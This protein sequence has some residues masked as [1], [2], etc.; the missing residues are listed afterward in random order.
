MRNQPVTYQFW[1]DIGSQGWWS[2]LEQPLTQPYVLSRNWE[3]NKPWTDIEEYEVNQ[4]SLA[5]LTTGL[6]RR[7]RQHVNMCSV[8]YN[9]QGLEERGALLLAL[10]NI[11]RLKVRQGEERNV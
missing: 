10:Q 11:Q 1:V 4:Q 9:E 3:P 7:C 8:A 2:R 5:R 6:L